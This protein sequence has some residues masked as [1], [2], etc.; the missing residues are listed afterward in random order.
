MKRLGVLFVGDGDWPEFREVRQWLAAAADL[1]VVE[2]P[3]R[4]GDAIAAGRCDP[5]LIVL[6]ERRPGEFAERDVAALRR[7][8]PLT[9]INELL[10]SWCEG[11]TL[12]GTPLPGTTRC[13]WHQWIARLAPEFARAAAGECPLWGLPA[14]ASEE[15]RLLARRPAAPRRDRGLLTIHVRHAETAAALCDAAASRG[16][17]AVWVRSLPLPY[18]AGIRVA[19]WE[20]TGG[21]PAQRG[22]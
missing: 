5:A 1:L 19:I 3:R 16:F 4:A 8:A 22:R 10:G 9:P 21:A 7:R 6:A 14:T 18:L 20:A 2:N 13:Y 12:S 11:Q 17:A 15:D